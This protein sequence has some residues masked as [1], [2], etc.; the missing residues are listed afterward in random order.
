M[1]KATQ[2]E[3]GTNIRT[4][5][6]DAHDGAPTVVS[7]PT[8]HAV[9]RDERFGG[10]DACAGCHEFPFPTATSR[11]DEAMMQTTVRE[12]ARSPAA[13]R[14]CASC[15]MPPDRRGRPSHGFVASRDPE[16]VRSAVGI[17]AER[18]D[19]RRV[20]VTLTPRV[21]GHAFPTGDLFRRVE[22]SAEAVGVD[23]MV[24]SA[25]RRYLARH[26]ALRDG[27]V[28]RRLL[29]DDRVFFEPVTVELTLGAEAAGR[30]VAWRV[31]YQRVAHPVG[32]DTSAAA[33]DGEV[34]LGWGWLA[35]ASRHGQTRR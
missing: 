32:Q 14:S 21:S 12:H 31:A 1:V 23:N 33:V 29:R 4:P 24:L 27:H 10:A 3:T 26:F 30:R 34:V 28:G 25:D 8:P 5:R 18:V 9:L 35:P 16:I 13:D 7:G 2:H 20:R 19:A 6:R 17:T 11:R 22:V 15:H